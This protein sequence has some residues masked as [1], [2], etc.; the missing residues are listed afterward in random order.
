M[1]PPSAIHAVFITDAGYALPT[2]VAVRSLRD[3]RAPGTEVAVHVLARGLAPED[4]ALLAGL[5]GERFAVDLREGESDPVLDGLTGADG[6]VSSSALQKF[7]LADIFPEL[8][9][10]LYL[11]GDILVEK[12]LSALWKTDLEGAPLAAVPD[13]KMMRK[14]MPRRLGLPRDT[15]FN[16][17]VMLLDLARWRA[18]GIAEKLV[19]WKLHG[20]NFLMDQDAFN[21]VLGDRAKW[22]PVSANFGTFLLDRSCLPELR[23]FYGDATLT[24]E[25]LVSGI[26]ILHCPGWC[27]PWLCYN[28]PGSARWASVYGELFPGRPLHRR[29]MPLEERHARFPDIALLGEPVPPHPRVVVSLTSHPARVGFVAATV[30]SVLDGTVPPDAIEV[31]LGKEKFPGGEADLPE[32]LLALVASSEGRVAVRWAEK[33]LGP[34][35]K[36]LYAR[37]AHPGEAVVTVDDDQ[38]YPATMLET[39]LASFG[40]H[41]GAVSACRA[42][43]MVMDAGTVLP[44]SEW[45]Q[46]LAGLVDTPS[47]QLLATGVCGVLYPPGLLPEKLFDAETMLRLSPRND[48]LWFKAVELLAGVPVV[49]AGGIP[50][51][52]IQP[53]TVESG[54]S[55]G[56]V[57]GHANDSQL[58]ALVAWVEEESGLAVEELVWRGGFAT[59]LSVRELNAFYRAGLPSVRSAVRKTAALRFAGK[60]DRLLAQRE[61]L[62]SRRDALQAEG[63]ALKKRLARLERSPLLRLVRLAAAPFRR[64]RALARRAAGK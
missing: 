26:E 34:A 57:R 14:G 29:M 35:T 10:I 38:I 30:R 32:D 17:G 11:D 13:F 31:W 2:A 58:A 9:R 16:S 41:P 6:H 12:D 22:L 15:Y 63:K 37:Q 27:K 39:L 33:D 3:S 55:I 43:L 51:Q 48:D 44:Y 47:H 25:G 64:L 42:H 53:D 50:L 40:E 46:D 19:D 7:H 45:P 59:V 60:R 8:D 21:A 24:L 36:L 62:L 18:D 52:Q 23:A 54:L 28:A 4:R 5:A 1:T 61:K 49:Q 20:T 56:N